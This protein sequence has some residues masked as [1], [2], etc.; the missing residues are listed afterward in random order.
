MRIAIVAEGNAETRQSWSGSAFGLLSALRRAGHEVT[1]IDVELGGIR[2]TLAAA[3]AFHPRRVTWRERF[4]LGNSSFRIRSR[5]AEAQLRRGRFDA[6]IQIGATF[7]LS[8]RARQ[9]AAYVVYCDSNIAQ[10]LRG[11]P[12]SNATGLLEN[13]VNHVLEREKGVYDSAD[14]VWAMSD[15]LRRSFHTDFAQPEARLATIGA[16][17][18]RQPPEPVPV[19]PVPGAPPTILFIGKDHRRK[20][21]S[22]LLEAFKAIRAELP[23]ARLHIAGSNPPDAAGPGV[24]VHGF[25]SWSNPE[26]AALQQQLYAQATVFCMP[27]RYEP[28]GIVFV[29]AML[30]ALPCIG[31]NAWAMPEIIAAGETGWLVPDGDVAALTAA[32]REALADP[33]RS[34]AMGRAGRERALALFTWDRVAE[35]AGRDLA[36]LRRQAGTAPR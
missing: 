30:S 16:G 26:H 19:R 22:L 25:L 18:N 13:Q 3:L 17:A 35:R 23:E 6:V 12:Y 1:A 33:E 9:G 14:R 11:R 29:E 31:T 32:L 28:F 5:L 4:R 36:T 24:H 20:G 27:S 10:A 2:R 15:A 21:L 8:A 7:A 34:A